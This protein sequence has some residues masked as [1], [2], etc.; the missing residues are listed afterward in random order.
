MQ[1]KC[2]RCRQTIAMVMSSTGGP[3]WIAVSRSAKFMSTSR[4]SMA[5]KMLFLLIFFSA[6]G[7]AAPTCSLPFAVTYVPCLHCAVQIIHQCVFHSFCVQQVEC[8]IVWPRDQQC[9]L[10]KEVFWS[11]VAHTTAFH[12]HHVNICMHRP[13]FVAVLMALYLVLSTAATLLYTQPG[14]TPMFWCLPRRDTFP[15]V[16]ETDA[17]RWNNFGQGTAATTMFSACNFTVPGI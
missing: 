1:P 5:S 3:T 15:I 7:S 10:W 2:S 17:H 12:L 9:V 14:S 4:Q 11:A 16:C 8:P 6:C 13:C